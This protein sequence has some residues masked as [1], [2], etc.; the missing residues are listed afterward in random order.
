M[1]PDQKCDTDQYKKMFSRLAAH[2]QEHVLR[3]WNE[4]DS[5]QRENLASQIAGLDL[6]ELDRLIAGQD[7]KQDFSAIT[8]AAVSPPHVRH[9]GTGVSWTAAQAKAAGE[10][11]LR[12]GKVGAVVVA[13]GQGTRLGFDLPKGMYPI[14]PVSGRT[15]FQFFADTLIAIGRKYESVIPWYVMTS[16]AT[17]DQTREYFE[18]QNYFGLDRR[19]VIIFKQGTMPAVDSNTGKL[20]MSQ[21][22]S[23]SMSPDGHG[24]TVAA[25]DRSGSLD[26]ARRRGVTVLSYIQVDNPLANLCD[27]TLIGHHLLSKSEMTTQVVRKRYAMEKVGN[28]VSVGGKVQIIEYSDLP[29]EAAEATD[30]QGRLKLW[31]GNIAVHVIDV[32]FLKRMQSSSTGFPFHR[33]DKK[34]PFL[35]DDGVLID[36][37]QTNATKFEKFIFDLLPQA[38][39]AFVVE[40]LPETAFAPV[41]NAAGSDTDTAALAQEAIIGL[42]R[43]WL[44]SRGVRVSGG[45]RVEISPQFGVC[46]DDLD[47]KVERGDVINCDQFWS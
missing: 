19:A 46:A 37:T 6:D 42:H 1:N 10:E 38:E 24:G 22:D 12:Q 15:L 8:A 44:E 34:V 32:A 13:G 33:A 36:P 28:V 27:P 7:I 43:G 4:L 9:D 18:R 30:E 23:L 31:A 20:L 26:D 40:S 11:A 25:L 47:G 41:K 14:G 5:A 16:D 29:R 39:N 17:D 45:V 2:R 3:Y 35:S 21:R